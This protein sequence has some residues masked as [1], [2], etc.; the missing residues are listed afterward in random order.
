MKNIQNRNV[1]YITILKLVAYILLYRI[2][3]VIMIA[4]FISLIPY[5]FELKILFADVRKSEIS[6]IVPVVIIIVLLGSLIAILYLGYFQFEHYKMLVI[7]K[8]GHTI[9]AKIQILFFSH[10][11]SSYIIKNFRNDLKKI[12]KKYE[13]T[14]ANFNAV[15]HTIFVAGILE[16]LVSKEDSKKFVDDIPNIT[17]DGKERN[18]CNSNVKVS[19]KY[20]RHKLNSNKAIRVHILPLRKLVMAARKEPFYKV[21]IEFFKK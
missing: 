20:L 4:F 10:R 1:D 21:T 13:G 2:Y 15:T 16:T 8:K 12:E 7:K 3:V 11:K 19:V 6:F 17:S 14:G 18:Y 5:Y 9:N